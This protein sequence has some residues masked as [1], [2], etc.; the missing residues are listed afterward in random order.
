M[1]AGPGLPIAESV[2]RRVAVIGDRRRREK[3]GEL[4]PA[5][6]V[7]RAHHGNLDALI[8]QSSDTSGPFSF[9][10]GPP[11]SSRPSS[12]KNSIVAARSSTT[13]PTLSIRLSAMCQMY[14]A[15]SILTM[16]R[17]LNAEEAHSFSS[18]HSAET[19]SWNA[20]RSFCATVNDLQR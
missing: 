10:R 13:I 12:R 17:G 9:D 14:L 15:S 5:V 1:A 2:H 18:E 4:E 8:A 7:R 11:S 20:Q 19:I 16:D 6:P 3:T